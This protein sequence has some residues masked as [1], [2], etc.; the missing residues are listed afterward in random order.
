MASRPSREFTDSQRPQGDDE[1]TFNCL[2]KLVSPMT[3][4]VF[5]DANLNPS[6]FLFVQYSGVVKR[7]SSYILRE[8]SGT[9]KGLYHLFYG[10][11][12]CYSVSNMLL[13]FFL[14]CVL[15]NDDLCTSESRDCEN[16]CPHYDYDFDGAD[17]ECVKYPN[18]VFDETY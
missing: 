11:C 15:H 18:S 2:K 4:T 16:S 5:A 7:A 13:F 8:D 6:E 1:I 3:Y 14:L 12:F 17:Y 10:M 9:K